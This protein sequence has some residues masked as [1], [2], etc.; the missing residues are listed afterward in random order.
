MKNIK[1][2]IIITLSIVLH[3]SQA[4]EVY[5]PDSLF[6]NYKNVATITLATRNIEKI[7]QIEDIDRCFESFTSN[8]SLIKSK[9]SDS[10]KYSKMQ[11]R[12]AENEENQI[13]IS[14]NVKD[15]TIFYFGDNDSFYE[16]QLSKYT[17]IIPLENYNALSVQVNDLNVLDDLQKTGMNNIIQSAWN[18]RGEKAK[19]RVPQNLYFDYNE[20]AIDADSRKVKT[21]Y[22]PMDQIELTGGI[23]VALDQHLIVPDLNAKISFTFANKGIYRSKYS[24]SMQ[25]KYFFDNNIT[26]GKTDI[27]INPFLN[28]GY[29]HNFSRNHENTTWYGLEVGYLLKEKGSHFDSNTFKVALS[30]KLPNKFIIA[31]EI[32]ISDDFYPGL[33]LIYGF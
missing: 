33:R 28:I 6:I 32:Y 24:V 19:H 27:N 8:F 15:K 21:H 23:G 20:N 9:L 29:A 30:M 1:Y 13:I 3:K 7:N 18:N 17:I 25:W 26:T 16:L 10:L 2:L 14:E 11:Y 12:I 31:P 4:Q 22:K 5:I